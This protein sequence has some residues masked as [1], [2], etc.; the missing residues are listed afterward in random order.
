MKHEG[1]Q[2]KY[3]TDYVKCTQNV[4]T[5][6]GC[7]LGSQ[8]M[9]DIDGMKSGKTDGCFFVYKWAKNSYTKYTDTRYRILKTEI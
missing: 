1:N 2:S 9:T 8:Q 3:S 7:S 4:S 6:K 5:I